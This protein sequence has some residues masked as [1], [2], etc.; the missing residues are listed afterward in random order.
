M[1]SKKTRFFRRFIARDFRHTG[2]AYP[3]TSMTRR[4]KISRGCRYA[5]KRRFTNKIRH[6]YRYTPFRP[7]CTIAETPREGSML[8]T[9]TQKT[10]RRWVSLPLV[11]GALGAGGCS[12]AH[13]P[14]AIVSQAELAVQ[15]ADKS[16]A[17]AYAPRELGLN[18]TTRHSYTQAASCEISSGA[19]CAA[20]NAWTAAVT[21]GV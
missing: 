5:S 17:S 14:T 1:K 13:P 19:V 4:E 8:M 6:D 12:A 20:C 3:D 16:K 7:L 18:R 15:Q 11:C 21:C 9:I 10:L 2:C